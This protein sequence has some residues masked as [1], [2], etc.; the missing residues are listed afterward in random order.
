MSL[1]TRACTIPRGASTKEHTQ[2]IFWDVWCHRGALINESSDP[3]ISH[4]SPSGGPCFCQAWHE[5]VMVR[6]VCQQP[7]E[8]G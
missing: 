6:A 2:S 4:V 1:P 5:G 8:V 7:V 3:T